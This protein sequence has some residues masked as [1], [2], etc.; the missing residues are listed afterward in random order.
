MKQNRRLHVGLYLYND[1]RT[2]TTERYIYCRISIAGGQAS[3][4]TGYKITKSQWNSRITR[5]RISTREDAIEIND[6]IEKVYK[7][8]IE[9][10]KDLV[11]NK[12]FITAKLMKQIYIGEVD[13]VE[14][15]DQTLSDAFTRYY[16]FKEKEG[17]KSAVLGQI[18]SVHKRVL[19]CLKRDIYL[20]G[21]GNSFYP[22]LKVSLF[23]EKKLKQRTVNTYL[24]VTKSALD[25]AEMFYPEFTNP[26]KW[27]TYYKVKPK[28]R[29]HTSEELE[30]L[31][32]VELDD[33]LTPYLRMY[34]LQLKTGMSFAELRAFDPESHLVRHMDDGAIWINIRRKKTGKMCEIPTNL[35]EEIPELGGLLELVDYFR[36][37]IKQSR[38]KA[39][40]VGVPS[41]AHYITKLKDVADAI[42]IDHFTSHQARHTFATTCINGGWSIVAVSRMIGDTIQTTERVYANLSSKRIV[43]EREEMKRKYAN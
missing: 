16:Q 6:E 25:H 39:G 34:Q 17:A 28:R 36:H 40:F 30:K 1:P 35:E 9:I 29:D 2:S 5:V 8:I 21:I 42:G 10:Y 43:K 22:D 33:K 31:L 27:I 26:S 15:K 37:R 38:V 13:S 32:S 20:Q 4:S 11:E 14:R 12:D 23:H 3:F 7:D 19:K 18:K 24:M 41:V